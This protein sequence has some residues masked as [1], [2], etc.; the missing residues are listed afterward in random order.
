MTYTDP[1]SARTRE[2]MF[3]ADD[4]AHDRVLRSRGVVR[5]ATDPGRILAR[6]PLSNSGRFWVRVV[7]PHCTRMPNFGAFVDFKRDQVIRIGRYTAETMNAWIA[8]GLQVVLAEPDWDAE[9]CWEKTKAGKQ[10]Q[11]DRM[12]DK[13]VCPLHFKKGE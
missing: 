9:K 1:D 10:C 11:Q 7:A 3:A 5:E 6:I 4:E 13:A 2:E 12:A 8:R